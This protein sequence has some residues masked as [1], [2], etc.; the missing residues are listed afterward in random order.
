MPP[1]VYIWKKKPQHILSVCVKFPS[2][3]PPFFLASESRNEVMAVIPNCTDGA[4]EPQY[5][6]VSKISVDSFDSSS[7]SSG[8]YYENTDGYVIVTPGQ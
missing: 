7:T 3:L 6:R 5:S 2:F 4:T 1:N 8:E